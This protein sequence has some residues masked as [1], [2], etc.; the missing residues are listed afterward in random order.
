[1]FALDGTANV[2]RLVRRFRFSSVSS[3]LSKALWMMNAA[4]RAGI[5]KNA[6]TLQWVLALKPVRSYFH[7]FS[8]FL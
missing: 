4:D 5:E 1:V 7:R 3:I 6:G 8:F 2:T